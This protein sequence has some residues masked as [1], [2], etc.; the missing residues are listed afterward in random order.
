MI[1]WV[2]VLYLGAGYG[3]GLTSVVFA[4]QGECERNGKYLIQQ[5]EKAWIA[6]SWYRCIQRTSVGKGE[7]K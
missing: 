1:E 6:Q 5:F 7:S 2:L 3:G 4:N